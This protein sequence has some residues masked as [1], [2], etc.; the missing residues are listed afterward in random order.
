L[1][2]EDSK[3]QKDHTSKTGNVDPDDLLS[4]T[5]RVMISSVRSTT[6]DAEPKKLKVS[7][8]G[9]Y[10][11]RLAVFDLNT[12]SAKKMN[13]QT[14]EEEM[15]WLWTRQIPNFVLAHHT[16]GRFNNIRAQDVREEMRHWEETQQPALVKF[17]NLLQMIILC[18]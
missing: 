18:S 1:I 6:E 15:P 13:V 17:A 10:I 4:S 5:Q 7:K 8:R 11:S 9:R 16:L 14:V 3:I 2:P 12:R